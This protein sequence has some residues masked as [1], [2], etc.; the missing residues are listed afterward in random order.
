MSKI[1]FWKKFPKTLPDS[2][3]GL[4]EFYKKSINPN[5]INLSVGAYRDKNGDPYIFESV[6]RA[7]KIINDKKNN[8]EYSPILGC[9]NFNTNSL[10]LALGNNY[11]IDLIAKAQTISG[12]GSL[13]IAVEFLSKFYNNENKTI[14]LSNPSWSNH[15]NIFLSCG[16]NIEYYNYLDEK[17]NLNIDEIKTTLSS[18]PNKSIVLF[19]ACCHN[20]TGIDPNIEQWN[21]I[22]NIIKE[23]NHIILFDMAYQG[24]SSGNPYFD[25]NAVRT[26]YSMNLQ[27]ILCQSYSKNFGLYGERA[28]CLS[29]VTRNTQEKENIENQLKQIIRPMYSSPPINGA[30]IINEILSDQDLTDLWL[31]DCKIVYERINMTRKLLKQKLDTHLPD[32][33]WDFL[34]NQ[35]GMFSYTGIDEKVI[36]FLMKNYDI[37]MTKDGRISISSLNE[38]N[39]EY[40][41]KSLKKSFK[42]TK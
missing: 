13:R 9:N 27:F 26:A 39:I 25:A 38:N 20:P 35:N 40:F 33:N 22:L 19:H 41:I 17:L 4:S 1:S 31:K 37:F 7:K 24:F 2:I 42:A 21:T 29:F 14:Y 5:K 6:K 16:F 34:N 32:Y 36:D 12:T 28:G 15:K 30:R 10:S 18:I 3:L 23:K 8:H 11:D